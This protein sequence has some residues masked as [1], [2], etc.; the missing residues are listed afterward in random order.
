[1]V[2]SNQDFS[3]LHVHVPEGRCHD[4]IERLLGG[5]YVK[6]AKIEDMNQGAIQNQYQ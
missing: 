4:A 6:Q 5:S 3:V 2:V 1:M